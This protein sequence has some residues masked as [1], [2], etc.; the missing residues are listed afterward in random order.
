VSQKRDVLILFDDGTYSYVSEAELI[1][2]LDPRE[3][4]RHAFGP[5]WEKEEAVD[6]ADYLDALLDSEDPPHEIEL[7]EDDPR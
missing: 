3:V 1:D 2:M 4:E 7:D 5:G 6:Y